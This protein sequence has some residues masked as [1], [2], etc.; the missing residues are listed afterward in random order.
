MEFLVEK[1]NYQCPYCHNSSL[2]YQQSDN[3]INESE[4]F[5]YIIKRK[6]IIEGIVIS[7]GEPT[8][9]KD[10]ISFLEKLRKFDIAIKIDT[11]GSLPNVLKEIIAKKLV[12]YI[13]M[14]IKNSIKKYSITTAIDNVNTLNVLE[15]INIIK[16][17]NIDHE[18]RTTIVKE[19]H[20]LDDLKEIKKLIGKSKYYLQ[21][22]KDT[23]SVIYNNL[24]GFTEEELLNIQ[25]EVKNVNIRG[26][27]IKRKEEE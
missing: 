3:Q 23:E 10:L 5:D 16:N 17:C 12:D 19:L 7:G 18:F 1:C 2:V 15:S 13:A 8:L 14:D 26:L 27:I 6:G 25:N 9:Q 22:F 24:H 11:N 21:N 4:I 20:D